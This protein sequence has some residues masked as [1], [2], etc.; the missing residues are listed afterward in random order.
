MIAAGTPTAKPLSHIEAMTFAV[1]AGLGVAYFVSLSVMY[2]D[3]A[4]LFNSKGH[5]I[6]VDFVAYWS[7]GR[8][9][10]HG[11]SLAPYDRHLLHAAE[12]AAIGTN[13]PDRLPWAYPPLFLFVAVSVACLPLASAFVIWNAATLALQSGVIAAIARSRAA[14]FVAWS[15]PWAMIGLAHGQ[16]QFLTSA[17]I[18]SAL[19]L[20][21]RRPAMSGMILGLLGYKPQLALLFPVALVAGRYW[22]ALAWSCL[23]TLAWTALSCAVF[24]A[25]TLAAFVREMSGGPQ[26]YLTTNAIPWRDVQSIYGFARAL[27]EPNGRAWILQL[28]IS[29]VCAI[30]VFLL[31]RSRAP[32]SLK[33]AGLAAAVPLVTPYIFIYDYAVLSIAIAFLFTSRH[34]DKAEYVTLGFALTACAVFPWMHIPSGPIASATILALV[35]RRCYGCRLRS[36]R[37][38]RLAS[39]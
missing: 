17:I 3:H 6:A 23:G 27:G 2:F 26:A 34:F 16:N 30:A 21:E 38:F 5:P 8:L 37:D 24:G 29:V 31:W 33:A 18:G 12:V 28:S 36:S 11:A 9:V 22:R 10:L 20:L 39:M 7:A 32:F 35:C 25:G 13:F 1:L 19:L 14:F 15:P 4:W